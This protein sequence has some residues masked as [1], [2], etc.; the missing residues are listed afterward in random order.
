V[1]EIP[2][3]SNPAEKSE[4]QLQNIFPQ[5]QKLSQ[6]WKAKVSAEFW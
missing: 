6:G 4:L 2:I 1:Q 3:F 5:L